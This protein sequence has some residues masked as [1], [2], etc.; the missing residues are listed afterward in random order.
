MKFGNLLIILMLA[1]VV[2]VHGCKKQEHAAPA[3]SED[4][5]LTKKEIETM[6]NN[7]YDFTAV[8]L[9]GKTV[10]MQQ[11][12]GKVVLVVNTA[13][14]CGYTKQYA[15]LQQLHEKYKDRGL[16]ILGFPCNQFGGQE[17][18][19]AEE[20]ETFCRVNYGVTFDMFEKIDV[21]G[22]DAH[23]I[24]DY[25]TGKL[26]GIPGKAIKWN[27]TKFLIDKDGTPV[28]RF[29]STATPQEIEPIIEKML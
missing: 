1:A 4:N 28:K 13:S 12:K 2:L 29:A 15:G 14:K 9:D 23:P 21:N 10:S 18:G 7:F 17:P 3:A 19:T 11:Y 24:F 26:P 6:E 16:A 8:T 27:F 5:D 20:I 25:L 22:D